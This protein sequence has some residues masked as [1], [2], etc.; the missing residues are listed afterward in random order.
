MSTAFMTYRATSHTGQAATNSN[1]VVPI[2]TNATRPA[3][4][5]PIYKTPPTFFTLSTFS[6][7]NMNINGTTTFSGGKLK[8]TDSTNTGAA[9]SAYYVNKL[10]VSS[11]TSVF[12][13]VFQSTNADGSTFIIQNAASNALGGVGGGIGYQGIGSSLAITLKTYD[14][15]PGVFSTQIVTGGTTLS[16]LGSSG[17][18]NSSLGLTA[19]GTWNF[20]V[21]VTYNGANLAYTIVNTANSNSFSSNANY[22][23]ST[24]V[25][26]STAWFGFTSGTGGSTET[27]IVNSWTHS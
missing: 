26:G 20:N 5:F 7:A 11:F 1:V 17:N 24:V 14:G 22:S 9:A 23:I 10:P 8:L 21:T 16:L 25:G 3:F 4:A 6:S 2:K 15:T 13:M 12:N 18:L 27:C 19:G